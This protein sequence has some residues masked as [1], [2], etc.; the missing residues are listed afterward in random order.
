MNNI[1]AIKAG[2]HEKKKK[3][4]RMMTVDIEGEC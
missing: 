3:D 1:N 2:H 4:E